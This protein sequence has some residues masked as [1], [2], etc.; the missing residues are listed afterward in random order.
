MSSTAVRIR[1][2]VDDRE[3]PDRRVDRLARMTFHDLPADWPNRSVIDPELFLDVVDIC[4]GERDRATGAVYVLLC[5]AEQRLVQPCAVTGGSRVSD[6]RG[7]GD[8]ERRGILD[9]FA[10][11][12]AAQA[13]GGG[14]VVVVARPGRAT[15]TEA[16]RR[17]RRAGQ[18]VCERHGIRLL[19]AAVATPNG[20]A[21]LTDE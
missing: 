19:A 5:D 10:T 13:A 8:E 6:T 4:V 11:A 14:L 1:V 15:P 7:V 18:E 21:T 12:L 2:A 3:G 20:I 16:D 9:P 17:W